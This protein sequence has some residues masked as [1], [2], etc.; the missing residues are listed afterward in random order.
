MEKVATGLLVLAGII[1]LLAVSGVQGVE[2]LASLTL[3][4]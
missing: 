3:C 1:H 2:R 4:I